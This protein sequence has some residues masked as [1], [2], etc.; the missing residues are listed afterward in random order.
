MLTAENAATRHKIASSN[1]NLCLEQEVGLGM[2]R[3]RQEVL[4][5]LRRDLDQQKAASCE[6]AARQQEL[7]DNHGLLQAQRQALVV[8]AEALTNERGALESE[9]D[10]QNSQAA[11]RDAG[12][13][14]A[15][16]LAQRNMV[17]AKQEEAMAHAKLEAE[18]S[19]GHSARKATL[20]AQ[21]SSKLTELEM[22]AAAEREEAAEINESVNANSLEI[23]KH[24]QGINCSDSLVRDFDR[25]G[26]ELLTDAKAAKSRLDTQRKELVATNERAESLQQQRKLLQERRD[27]WRQGTAGVFGALVAMVAIAILMVNSAT[28]AVQE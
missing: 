24:K 5:S 10:V 18:R 20:E 7:R 27:A 21:C 2:Q 6:L 13:L 14:A 12:E 22:R 4:R 16:E 3:E 11:V 26:Q 1:N 28:P 8:R 23:D 17:K 19:L 25:R 9:M 15:A